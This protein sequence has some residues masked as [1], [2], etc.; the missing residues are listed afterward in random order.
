[1]WKMSASAKFPHQKI[2]TKNFLILRSEYITK[3]YIQLRVAN[4]YINTTLLTV[5]PYFVIT[6]KIDDSF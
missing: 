5:T 3:G 4:T 1:M 6:V 2:R